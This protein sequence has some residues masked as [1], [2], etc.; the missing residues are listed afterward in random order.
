[1]STGQHNSGGICADL[2]VGGVLE[3]A[4]F[5]QAKPLKQISGFCNC[6]TQ[7]ARLD[8]LQHGDE[9]L[10][11]GKPLAMCF[12]AVHA[13]AGK[14]LQQHFLEGKMMQVRERRAC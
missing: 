5:Y 14:V 1:M 12:R 11:P 7:A 3:H 13:D 9:R 4:A 2:A 10:L 8:L 6:L